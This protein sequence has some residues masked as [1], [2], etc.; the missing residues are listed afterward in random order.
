MIYYGVQIDGSSDF[1]PNPGLTQLRMSI[2]ASLES[3]SYPEAPEVSKEE[4]AREIYPFGQQEQ[5]RVKTWKKQWPTE[6]AER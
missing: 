6:P 3:A 5:L 1:D 4:E 2:R